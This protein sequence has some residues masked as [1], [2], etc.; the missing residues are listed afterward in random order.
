MKSMRY[1]K[2]MK[3]SIFF[4]FLLTRKF[5]YKLNDSLQITIASKGL[6][7]SDKNLQLNIIEL[8]MFHHS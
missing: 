3:I 5:N 1:N 8:E 6:N 2:F 4:E 7:R